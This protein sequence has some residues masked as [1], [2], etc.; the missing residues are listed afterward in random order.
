M[1][2]RVTDL[3]RSVPPADLDA[4]APATPEWRVRDLAAHLAGVCDDGLH[5][6][7]GSVPSGGP[8]LVIGV[9]DVEAVNSWTDV[10][11][12]K[13]ADWPIEQVLDNW[14]EL[15]EQ[16]EATMN[17]LHPAIGQML[18]DAVTHEHD[19]RGGLGQPDARDSAAMVIAGDWL[20]RLMSKLLGPGIEGT[21]RIE[22]EG[23]TVDIGTG[24]PVTT[25]RTTRF[26]ILRVVTGRRSME[27]MRAMDWNGPLDP[28]VLIVAPT[29]YPPRPT[30]LIE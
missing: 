4:I 25:L 7:L 3:L 8:D 28:S 12:T 19:I 13:R 5:G 11:V 1:R 17:A 6:N 26:E 20:L 14:A 29:L 27:Q 16:I 18:A 21:L 23:G 24:E 10:Q 15:A 22:H 2:V 30:N 9:D